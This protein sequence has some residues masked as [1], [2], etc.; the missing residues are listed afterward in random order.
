[1]SDNPSVPDEILT[2]DDQ[3]NLISK[4]TGR[5]VDI[6]VVGKV[7]GPLVQTKEERI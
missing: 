3:D 1:M 7:L 4:E 5:P 2:L 6:N